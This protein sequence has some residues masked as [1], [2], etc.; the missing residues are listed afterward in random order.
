[1]LRPSRLFGTGRLFGRGRQ[2]PG[3]VTFLT[4]V[5][6]TQC[7][8]LQPMVMRVAAEAG[9]PL[10]VTDVDAL[11]SAERVRWTD[12]VPVVLLD[13]HEHASWEIE[14]KRLRKALGGVR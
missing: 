10:T 13:D 7:A 8:R 14:E 12:K 4:R 2:A 9:L 1:M 5:G 3:S 6:C 11:P